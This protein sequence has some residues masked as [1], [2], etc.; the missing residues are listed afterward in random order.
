MSLGHNVHY[1]NENVFYGI[2]VDNER[3]NAGGGG[4]QAL[5]AEV[6]TAK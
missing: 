6:K 4:G 2:L 5:P 3:A 1:R